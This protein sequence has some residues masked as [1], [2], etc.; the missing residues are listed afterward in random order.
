[1][2]GLCKIDGEM[3]KTYH[4]LRCLFFT[5][6][7]ISSEAIAQ[8]TTQLTY[9]ANGNR[10]SKQ[11]RGSSPNPTVTASPEAVAP[12]QPSTLAASGCTGGSIQW[13]PV[14]QTGSQ[15]VVNP[16]AT[17]QYT[18]QCVVAGCA[19]NGFAR[20]TVS[21]IQCETI[22]ITAIPSVNAVKYGQ[23]V[24]LFAFGCVN[25]TVK[26]SSGQVGSPINVNMYGSSAVFTATCSRDYCPN[27]GSATIIV[28]G[29]SGCLTGDVIIS[30][31]IG[32]WHDPNTGIGLE[33]FY[34]SGQI[35]LH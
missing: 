25:G 7:V 34:P 24:T 33:S 16:T 19:N 23:P 10:I 9:D 18:A 20:T 22:P 11:V 13:Q 6:L 26:W 1:M 2:R 8:T 17:T 4:I 32:S 30:K 15:I 35:S 21:I 31:Q 27:L 28:G 3:G 5:I 29:I 12:S 14:N